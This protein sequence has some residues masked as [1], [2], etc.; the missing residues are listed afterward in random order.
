MSTEHKIP[1]PR[2]IY[3]GKAAL[4]R[5]ERSWLKISSAVAAAVVVVGVV[6]GT[7]FRTESSTEVAQVQPIQTLSIPVEPSG[8]Q[9]ETNTT[10]QPE[11]F[12]ST[13]QPKSIIHTSTKI[14]IEKHTPQIET[15]RQVIEMIAS[16]IVPDLE[17][18]C[19]NNNSDQILAVIPMSQI[20]D[21]EETTLR[22]NNIFQ[23]ITSGFI[24]KNSSLA[25]SFA[26]IKYEAEEQLGQLPEAFAGI[27][28]NF[29][30]QIASV[31][32]IFSKETN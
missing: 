8:Q 11:T 2:V 27:K 19:Q 5:T 13:E 10:T 20:Y 23:R 18:S 24:G 25:E 26:L 22:S 4:R 28:D 32:N 16:Q 1:A 14:Q 21:N 7:V 30:I 6:V 9:P 15:Q 31:R 29:S 12:S 17:V 3:S